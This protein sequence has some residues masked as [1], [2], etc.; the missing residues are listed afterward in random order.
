MS[1]MA[2]NALR[3]DKYRGARDALE[4]LDR[5]QTLGTDATGA[6]HHHSAYDDRVVVVAE[7]GRIERTFDLSDRKLSAY[8]AFVDDQRGWDDLRYAES[9]GEILREAI[10]A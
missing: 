8:V 9:F 3:P 1:D 4:S 5:P 2:T 7:D 10:G 6:V